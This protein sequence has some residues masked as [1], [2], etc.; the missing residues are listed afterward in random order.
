MATKRGKRKAVASHARTVV[1][2]KISDLSLYPNNART[3]TQEQV[4][5][6]AESITRFGFTNPVLITPEDL[7][8]GGHARIAAAQH[9]GMTTVP[10]RLLEGLSEDEV[11]AYII[12]D[13]R[14]AENSG[15]DK[16]LLAVEM[17][18]LDEV[19]FDLDI[20]GFTSDE[21][22]SLLEPPDI[23]FPTF[24]EDAADD[25]KFTECPECGHKWAK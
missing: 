1:D 24:S 17:T 14:L 2:R 25:V 11:K 5:E 22:T 6:V 19:G 23:T 4:E 10:T 7:V 18:A 12:A 20:L 16:G 9:L 13:N 15:W 8:V 21:V 3:H